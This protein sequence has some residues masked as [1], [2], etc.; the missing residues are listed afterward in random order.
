MCYL[1]FLN[2]ANHVD[3]FPLVFPPQ[4][5]PSFEVNS[6][7][8]KAKLNLDSSC[9]NRIVQ[10]V[11]LGRLL[12]F[13]PFAFDLF[14]VHVLLEEIDKLMLK[15]QKRNYDV[16][17]KCKEIW[18]EFPWAKMLK[19]DSSEIHRVNCI[20]CSIA[21]GKDVILGLKFNTLEK[22]VE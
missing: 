16:S 12:T 20:V 22:H 5:M 8:S 7:R 3:L 4:A 21:K 6:S 14:E 10:L 1:S 15:K 19:N 17:C 18:V 9:S 2:Q 11:C 13:V